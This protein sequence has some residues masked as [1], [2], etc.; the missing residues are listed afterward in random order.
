MS[1]LEDKATR[2]D[3][4]RRVVDAIYQSAIEQDG[5]TML[6]L[7]DENITTASAPYLPWGGPW[8]DRQEFLENCVPQLAAA[9]D[10]SRMS[11]EEVIANGNKA[12][13]TV[14]CF[15]RSGEQVINVEVWTVEH[16]KAV[17]MKA[18]C[19]DPRPLLKQLGLQ[20]G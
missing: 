5:A 11:V 1:M 18:Y 4:T 14:K 10:F 9:Y 2:T 13:A 7:L 20:L 19:L 3:E 16:G 12:V 8:R 15:A 17:D 6:A